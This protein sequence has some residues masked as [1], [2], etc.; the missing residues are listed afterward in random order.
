ASS[1]AAPLALEEIEVVAARIANGS[2]D[3]AAVERDLRKL[4]SHHP[5]ALFHLGD[6]YYYDHSDRGVPHDFRRALDCYS[7]ALDAGEAVAAVGVGD[8][9][10]FGH[11]GSAKQPG[12]A[13]DMYLRAMPAVASVAEKHPSTAA[14]IHAGIADVH[15]DS[16]EYVSALDHYYRAIELSDACKRA[17]A[18]IGDAHLYGRGTQVDP[19]HARKCYRKA[20]GTRREVEGMI[21]FYRARGE[22]AFANMYI[23]DPL[24]SAP[25]Y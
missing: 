19:D 15:Y 4:A 7:E 8:C 25:D 24:L 9:Y 12:L 23:N 2:E 3:L 17:W 22:Y 6:L 1:M 11:G 14:R 18:R 21:E 5:R 20:K 13:R 16:G 10:Y